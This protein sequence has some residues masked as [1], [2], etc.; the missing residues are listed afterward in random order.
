MYMWLY[1]YSFR[2]VFVWYIQ[3]IINIYI[4]TYFLFI[5]FSWIYIYTYPGLIIAYQ[6]PLPSWV[7]WTF[8]AWEHHGTCRR[9]YCISPGKDRWRKTPMS[10]FVMVPYYAA[11]LELCHLLSPRCNYFIDDLQ[12]F[13]VMANRVR[14]LK[15]LLFTMYPGPWN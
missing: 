15:K 12:W 6:Y 1:V 13:M 2:F 4:H 10:W 14:W 7:Y 8:V 9:N 11:F 3:F 5:Y